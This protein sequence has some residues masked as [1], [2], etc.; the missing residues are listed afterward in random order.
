MIPDQINEYNFDKIFYDKSEKHLGTLGVGY[1]KNYLVSGLAQK[2]ILL[3]SNKRLY[4]KGYAYEKSNANGWTR[5][6]TEKVVDLK[7]ITG[8]SFISVNPIAI[9]VGFLIA[10]TATTSWNI[11]IAIL[12]TIAGLLIYFFFKKKYLVIEYAG[13]YI[14][15]DSSAYNE[16]EISNFQKLISNLK[17]VHFDKINNA[18]EVINQINNRVDAYS[19]RKKEDRLIELNELLEKGLINQDEYSNLKKSIILGD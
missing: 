12:I 7:D 10:G 8:T 1:L 19:P 5:V 11:L 13:G 15:T 16:I 18:P 9:L 14:A 2:T 17:D 4:Q 6:R 3:L